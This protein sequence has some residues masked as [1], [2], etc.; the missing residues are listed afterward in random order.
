MARSSTCKGSQTRR[1]RI[2]WLVCKDQI[3]VIM[4]LLALL[5]RATK[6]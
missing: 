2:I 1:F 5:Y 6:E 3:E 4:L